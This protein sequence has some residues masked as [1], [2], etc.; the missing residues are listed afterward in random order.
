[1]NSIHYR[2]CKS[3][4]FNKGKISSQS[5]VS[6]WRKNE[7]ELTHKADNVS[8]S[9]KSEDTDTLRSTKKNATG[10]GIE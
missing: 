7:F 5:D 8:D 4:G 2:K 6:F 10:Q 3:L 1:M 9:L